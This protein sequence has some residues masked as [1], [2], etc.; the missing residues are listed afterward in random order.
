MFGLLCAVQLHVPID[1]L[2]PQ[3]LVH[4][5]R[6]RDQN[7]IQRAAVLYTQNSKHVSLGMDPVLLQCSFGTIFYAGQKGLAA[8]MRAL[9]L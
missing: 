3:L 1:L 2:E 5:L 4:L 9:T 8:D 6:P 7:I